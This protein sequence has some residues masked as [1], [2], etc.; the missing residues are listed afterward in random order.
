MNLENF[1]VS[2]DLVYFGSGLRKFLK[3]F[4]L[5]DVSDLDFEIFLVEFEHRII[6]GLDLKNFNLNSNLEIF[7]RNFN[8]ENF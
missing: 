2:L 3:D 8:F 5:R 7:H 1:Q 4:G 6:L